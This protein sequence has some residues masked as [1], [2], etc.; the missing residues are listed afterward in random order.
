M[1]VYA[2]PSDGAKGLQHADI[3]PLHGKLIGKFNSA[4][5]LRDAGDC[6]RRETGNH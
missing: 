5:L 1:R 4:T 3:G 2:P 6:V